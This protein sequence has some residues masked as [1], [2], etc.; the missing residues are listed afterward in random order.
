MPIEDN[1][2]RAVVDVVAVSEVEAVNSGEDE[3]DTEIEVVDV[4]D[5]V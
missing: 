5:S 4:G 1:V 3:G 2:N